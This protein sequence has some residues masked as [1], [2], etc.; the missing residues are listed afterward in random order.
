VTGSVP[1]GTLCRF[2]PADFV[3][4]RH[5]ASSHDTDLATALETARLLGIRLP[6][7]ITIWGVEAVE[8]EQFGELLTPVVAMAVPL[9]IAGIL[10]ELSSVERSSCV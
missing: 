2:S 1:P 9:V 6:R 10:G 5:A 8:V 4:T 3:A 7:E